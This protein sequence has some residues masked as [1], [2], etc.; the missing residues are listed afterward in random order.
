MLIWYFSMDPDIYKDV[1]L[2]SRGKDSNSCWNFVK[3]G[4]Q[5]GTYEEHLRI[6]LSDCKQIEDEQL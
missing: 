4:S 6:F 2:K 1:V 5:S 3:P